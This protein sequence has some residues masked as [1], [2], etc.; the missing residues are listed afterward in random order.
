LID[1]QQEATVKYTICL[2]YSSYSRYDISTEFQIKISFFFKLDSSKIVLSQVSNRNNINNISNNALNN[3]NNNIEYASYSIKPSHYKQIGEFIPLSH[4]NNKV[5][6]VSELQQSMTGTLKPVKQN[7]TTNHLRQ[8]AQITNKQITH[9]NFMK[10]FR[11]FKEDLELLIQRFRNL[12]K[13]KYS[14]LNDLKQFIN[15]IEEFNEKLLT[16]TNI[17]SEEICGFD[18]NNSGVE[19]NVGYKFNVGD[20]FKTFTK[21]KEYQLKINVLIEQLNSE[22]LNINDTEILD[23]YMDQLYKIF[24]ECMHLLEIIPNR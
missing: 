22:D 20:I 8:Q 6:P 1:C 7:T 18:E 21:L 11:Y 3:N 14:P 15:A 4:L 13:Q 10:Q 24:N 16:L 2:I 19:T 12:Q 9:F 23:S 5:L 17:Q